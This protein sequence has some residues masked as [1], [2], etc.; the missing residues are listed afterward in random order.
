MIFMFFFFQ[1]NGWIINKD[2]SLKNTCKKCCHHC[3]MKIFMRCKNKCEDVQVRCRNCRYF[4]SN[5]RLGEKIV[6]EW[7][8]IDLLG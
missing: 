6:K 7:W 2:G 1:D 3:S 4:E 5:I 8:D